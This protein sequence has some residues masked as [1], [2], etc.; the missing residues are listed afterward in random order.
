MG[1][2]QPQLGLDR[3]RYSASES[4]RYQPYRVSP[5]LQPIPVGRLC[6]EKMPK[7]RVERLI[8]LPAAM[9]ANGVD[10]SMHNQPCAIMLLTAFYNDLPRRVTTIACRPGTHKQSSTKFAGN[11]PHSAYTEPDAIDRTSWQWLNARPPEMCECLIVASAPVRKHR[12]QS[13]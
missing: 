4:G 3:Y 12:R 1:Q 8:S 5:I 9:A 13:V 11:L 7:Y 6:N 2:T 10:S